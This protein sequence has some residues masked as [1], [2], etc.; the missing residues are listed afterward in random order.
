MREDTLAVH[1]HGYYDAGLGVFIP[2]VY[3]TAIFEQRGE[4][5]RTDRSTELKYSR[6]ENPTVRAFERVMA[7]LEGGADAL[8]F[9]SGMAAVAATLLNHV[10][11][12]VRVLALAELY[13]STLDLLHRLSRKVGFELSLSWPETERVVEDIKRL[14]PSVVFVETI[15]NPMLRVIDVREVA[16]AC[17]DLG[18]ALIVD[19]TFATP[20]LVNPLQHGACVVIH[21]STKYISGHN[22]ALGG[23]AV[24]GSEAA[25]GDLW[26]WRRLLGG[27]LQ[28]FEAYLN[29]RGVK[30]LGVRFERQCS[31]AMALAEFLEG[32]SR[33]EAVYY[34]GL[35][36]SPYKAVADRV[37]KRRLYGGVVTFRLRGSREN[38]VK[39]LKSLRLA[40][41]APSL[42]GAET[43]V[44]WPVISA[45][46]PLS[47]EHR[48][49]LGITETVLRVSVGLENPEDIIEDIG[50]ALASSG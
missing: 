38:V 48:E 8:A 31:T 25:L 37:F 23:V 15:T 49:K 45:A 6:E 13:G 22:D 34:P 20:L 29:L 30:T 43:L 42:G 36:S 41:P 11:P 21:S 7:K 9:N 46:K 1:G 18:C 5:L 44:T 17:S 12:G 50:Q 39:F 4:T 33:V 35:S 40:R 24:L 28:P 2:P 32:H 47:A 19:N 27:I 16:G 10:D 14:R 26:D 3:L